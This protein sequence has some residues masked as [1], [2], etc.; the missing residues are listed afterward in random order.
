MWADL[1]KNY[2]LD[3]L[4][5]KSISELFILWADWQNIESGKNYM[6]E[7]ELYHLRVIL[8]GIQSQYSSARLSPPEPPKEPSMWCQDINK[9]K[10][11]I[12]E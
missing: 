2:P 3:V 8:W 11:Y 1:V 9:L 7:Q 4:E 10:K 12:D 5:D 6:K